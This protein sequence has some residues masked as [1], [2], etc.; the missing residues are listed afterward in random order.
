M[1]DRF[2]FRDRET[3]DFVSRY[4]VKTTSVPCFQQPRGRYPTADSWLM[5]GG[6]DHSR[7]RSAFRIF[8][9]ASLGL[10]RHVSLVFA[11]LGPPHSLPADGNNNKC[12]K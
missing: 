9:S 3:G 12:E 2:C 7:D 10:V 11:V 4:G 5:A 6:P 1:D 8:N